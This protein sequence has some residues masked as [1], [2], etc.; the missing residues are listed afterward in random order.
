M[1]T[2]NGHK[3]QRKPKPRPRIDFAAKAHETVDNIAERAQRAE[4]GVR[5]AAARTAE[6]ARQLQEER[7]DDGRA[8]PAPRELVRREQPARVRRYCVRGRRAAEQPTAALKRAPDA[9][10]ALPELPY[11]SDALEPLR[12]A[13]PS[14]C[15]TTRI[16][17]RT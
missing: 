11:G 3:G 16:T 5:G 6:Q 7:T 9:M 14:S 4:R 10:Y 8:K 13:E 2:S 1:T 15:I 17:R 12:I